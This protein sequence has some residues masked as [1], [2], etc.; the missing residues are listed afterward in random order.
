M[1]RHPARLGG[2][3]DDRTRV[4]FS[5]VGRLIAMQLVDV[6]IERTT[7]SPIIVLRVDDDSRRIL[8]IYIGIPEAQSIKFAMDGNT[9]ARPLTHDLCVALVEALGARLERLVITELQDR[10]FF[11]ELHIDNNG[12]PLQISCRP[13]DGVALAVRRG[14][15][16]FASED[17]VESSAISGDTDDDSAEAPENTEELVDEFRRFIEDIN[18]EDFKS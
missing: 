1:T 3:F 8:P 9:P 2:R 14:L 10:V 12:T 13:S 4:G 17:V 11:A 16:I 6:R 5:G 18:P 15:P 7:N